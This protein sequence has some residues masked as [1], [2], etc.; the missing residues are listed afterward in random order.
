MKK[1]N[2]LF[3]YWEYI[4]WLYHKMSHGGEMRLRE[5]DRFEKVKKELKSL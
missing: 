2:R 3:L 5:W 4:R 1:I